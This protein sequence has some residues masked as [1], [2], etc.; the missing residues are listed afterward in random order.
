MTLN[1]NALVNGLYSELDGRDMARKAQ[2]MKFENLGYNV[3]YVNRDRIDARG[4]P[5]SEFEAVTHYLNGT[6]DLAGTVYVAVNGKSNAEIRHL[7]AHEYQEAKYGMSSS[8]KEM[9]KYDHAQMELYNLHGLKNYDPEA[10]REGLTKVYGNP[11][12]S[13]IQ[14]DLEGLMN[15]YKGPVDFDYKNVIRKMGNSYLGEEKTKA[16]EN[17]YSQIKNKGLGKY[18]SG[19][20][21]SWADE[22]FSGSPA[23]DIYK[24][25]KNSGG[26]GNYIKNQAKITGLTLFAKMMGGEVEQEYSPAFSP[27]M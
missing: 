14:A 9:S 8:V 12:F 18:L 15:L 19:E 13:D 16:I 7:L 27:A 10:F 1:E 22:K 2:E 3:V 23:W 11:D 6:S 17:A 4:N 25:V 26:L 21:H 24:D 5:G 20:A